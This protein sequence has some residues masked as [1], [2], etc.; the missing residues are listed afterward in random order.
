MV[1][2]PKS[3]PFLKPSVIVPT[4]YGPFFAAES[5]V[6]SGPRIKPVLPSGGVVSGGFVPSDG[7][8]VP[9]GGLPE[10]GGVAPGGGV[11]SG[12][13][14]AGGAVGGTA[15]G[16]VVTGVEVELVPAVGS[17]AVVPA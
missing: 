10:L 13:L 6:G 1:A 16:G 12:G 15:A 5:G 8:V 14:V 2:P 7:G 9:V 3:G 11:V 17:G 4:W